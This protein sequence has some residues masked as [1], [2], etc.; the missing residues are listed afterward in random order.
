[1]IPERLS[2]SGICVG[3]RSS[4]IFG[5][6][7]V[8]EATSLQSLSIDAASTVSAPIATFAH[9]KTNGAPPIIARANRDIEQRVARVRR[10]GAVNMSGSLPQAT[11]ARFAWPTDTWFARF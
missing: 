5:P 9:S 11:N 3:A 1:M 8:R 6:T 10:L 2:G 7:D 4:S